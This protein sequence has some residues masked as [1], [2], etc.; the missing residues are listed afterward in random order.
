MQEHEEEE[1]P[2]RISIFENEK[3]SNADNDEYQ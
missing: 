2:D 1:T 3:E